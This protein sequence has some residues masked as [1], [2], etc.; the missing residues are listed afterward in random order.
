M[1][2]HRYKLWRKLFSLTSHGENWKLR[3]QSWVSPEFVSMRI[4]RYESRR[5]SISPSGFLDF[6]IFATT[7]IDGMFIDTNYGEN[8]PSI[9][10]TAKI[11]FSLRIFRF[12]DFR[13]DSYRWKLIDT[14]QGE[15]QKT[16]KS[17]GRNWFSPWLVSMESSSI[18]TMA[19][20]FHRYKL[21]R[22]LFS[23]TSHGENFIDTSQGENSSWILGSLYRVLGLTT[24]SIGDRKLD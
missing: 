7:R 8:I 16:Q 1:E 22:K 19:K 17:W 9:Q 13:H 3:G 11:N 4:H 23:L 5:K 10:V 20:I 6:L 15:N 24:R 14:S 18:Q 21:W 12:F 2:A